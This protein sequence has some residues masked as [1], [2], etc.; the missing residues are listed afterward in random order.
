[1]K[2]ENNIVANLIYSA[3]PQTV[4]MTMIAG[5]ILYEDGRYTTIDINSVYDDAERL[6]KEIR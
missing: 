6:M 3:S 5:K 1:M 4:R 2:P